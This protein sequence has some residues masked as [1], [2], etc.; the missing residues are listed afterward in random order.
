MQIIRLTGAILVIFATSYAGFEC[1]GRIQ[2]RINQLYGLKSIFTELYSDVEY[3]AC[4]LSESFG[5]MAEHQEKLYEVFL[6]DLSQSMKFDSENGRYQEQSFSCLFS[7]AVDQKLS[8][9]ALSKE[10]KQGLIQFGKQLGSNQ[11]QGQ[12]R[13][14]Q[15]Y[16]QKLDL[17]IQELEKTKSEKQKIIR[18]LGI[19][20]GMLLV[21][22]LL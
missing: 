5:K 13:L 18:I 10:D 21:I 17:K 1:S 19:S 2:K 9:S 14:I 11:K 3:G 12:L 8:Q 4:T 16:L 22:L 15:I 6:K 20:G 7:E